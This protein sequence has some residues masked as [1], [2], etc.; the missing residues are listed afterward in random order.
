MTVAAFWGE[1]WTAAVVNH[2]W[3]STVVVGVAWVLTL[4][5]KKNHARARYWVW[6][7][8]GVKF[9]LPFSVLMAAGEWLRSLMATPVVVRPEMASA[10]EQVTQPF[11]E[12]QI[13]GAAAPVETHHADWLPWVLLAVWACGAMVVAGRFARGWWRVYAAKRAALAVKVREGQFFETDHPSRAKAHSS[14]GGLVG[15]TEVVPLQNGDSFRFGSVLVG[16]VPVLCTPEL[17]EPGIFGIFRPVLLM[18][19]GILERL[20]AEQMR[21]VIAHEM[22]HVR[23]RDNLTFAVHMVVEVLFWFHPAVWWI[24]ARLIEERER[25]CDEAVVEARGQAEDYA[26]GILNVCKFCVES[27]VGCIAGVTGADLKKRIVR[28]MRGGAARKLGLGGKLVLGAAGLV[29]ITAP[30]VFGVAQAREDMPEW[31]KAAGGHAEFEVASIRLSGP[32]ASVPPSMILNAEDTPVPSGGLFVAD[33]PLQIFIEFA[34]KIMPSHEQEEAM[35]AH[36]PKWVAT[37]H[38]VIRAKFTGNP[39]KD[40]IRL[41]MQSLLADRFKLAVHFASSDA[42]VFALVVDKEGRLGP[43]I[44]A[45]PKG[46]PCNEAL[47]A[48]AD[49]FSSSVPPGGFVRHCGVVRGINGPNHTMLI[50]ARD[51]TLNHF[52]GYLSDFEDTGRPIVDQTG[53]NGAWDLSLNWLPE[54][55]GSAASANERS[56]GADGPPF[57]EALKDQLGLKLKPARATIPNLVIDHIERPSP[58]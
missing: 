14:S 18:P 25:A 28:I 9:L 30:V 11:A 20:T 3:Q 51:I 1:G 17:L 24:G 2:L 42:R 13:F 31:Q 4:A 38:F 29:A 41:M 35:L 6:F 19:E 49:P 21:A 34:W 57:F 36:L 26:E 53:L 12:G 55:F 44:R 48:P 5:L 56:A 23:W 16:E 7:A 52:A 50:G 27:P 40:Q 32:G 33:F 47:V 10:I 8:A 54:R 37:D 46:A 58:N 15:T 22:E 43:R 45:H 39:T